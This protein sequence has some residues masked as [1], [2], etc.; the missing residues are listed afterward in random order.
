MI[1][2]LL[3]YWQPILAAGAAL[4]VSYGTHKIVMMYVKSQHEIELATL[5]ADMTKKCKEAQAITREVSD[6]YQSQISA[7]NRRV[8]DLKRVRTQ[9]VP[10]Y[11]D[12]TGGHHG[13]TDGEFRGPD[14]G[15]TA[16]TLLDFARDAEQTR[17]QLIGC[18][19]WIKKVEKMN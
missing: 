13:S 10:F 2:V 17:L 11:S 7:L 4:L 5:L 6:E 14:G 18:Q 3:K 8:A 12:P 15:I 19:D 9:C 16:G 1:P